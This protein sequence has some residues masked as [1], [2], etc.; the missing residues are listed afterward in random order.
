MVLV[1]KSDENMKRLS[2]KLKDLA[3]TDTST[4][5]CKVSFQ[6]L[7]F[8]LGNPKAAENIAVDLLRWS[9]IVCK[10]LEAPH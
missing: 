1:H 6:F 8:V 5:S 2:I 4:F 7:C 10:K 9:C 3:L